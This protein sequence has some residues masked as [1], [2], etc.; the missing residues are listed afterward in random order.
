[1]RRARKAELDERISNHTFQVT[2][3]TAYLEGR[4]R[5]FDMNQPFCLRSQI[6]PGLRFSRKS[7]VAHFGLSSIIAGPVMR[8]IVKKR[9]QQVEEFASYHFRRL[10]SFSWNLGIPACPRLPRRVDAS[11]DVTEAGTRLKVGTVSGFHE[12]PLVSTGPEPRPPGGV[13]VISRVRLT[14]PA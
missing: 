12:S 7:S 9:F 6:Y 1:M 3:I 10:S 4:G 11:V 5:S 8:R 13:P 14:E 2:G